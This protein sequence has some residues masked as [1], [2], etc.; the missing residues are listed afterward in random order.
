MNPRQFILEITF[1]FLY[2]IGLPAELK[3][4]MI[5]AQEQRVRKSS[6]ILNRIQVSTFDN[7]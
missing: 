7:S 1:S 4:E 6:E 3:V 2:F 5:L